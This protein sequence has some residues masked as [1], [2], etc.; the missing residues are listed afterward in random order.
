MLNNEEVRIDNRREICD[1]YY[2]II[3]S[4]FLYIITKFIILLREERV[5]LVTGLYTT[6]I[7]ALYGHSKATVWL[8]Q[9]PTRLAT[10]G[11][12]SGHVYRCH[13]EALLWLYSSLLVE[14]S[15]SGQLKLWPCSG[16]ICKCNGSM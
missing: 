13:V 15:V 1:D 9:L 6:T 2:V 7:Q 3:M 14:V 11:S 10:N 12:S 8:L 4:L 5:M 16:L